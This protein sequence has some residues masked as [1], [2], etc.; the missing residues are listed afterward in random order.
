M[1]DNTVQTGTDTIATDDVTTLNGSASSG[2]KVPRNKM[3]YGDD[4]TSRDVSDA[5]ALPVR[6]APDD[7]AG[8]ITSVA[9]AT[10]SFTVLAA[11]TA[12]KGATIY[13]DSSNDVYLAFASSA[14]TSAYSVKI[15]PA[16]YYELPSGLIYRAVISAIALT[17]TGNL[18]VTELV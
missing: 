18:R 4:G 14:T 16:G 10:S 15:P 7:T 11:N 2:V 6:W 9:L 3:T 12:R 1:A 8:T 5:F 17:A 13:N